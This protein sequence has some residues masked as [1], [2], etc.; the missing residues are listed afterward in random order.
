MVDLGSLGPLDPQP[1]WVSQMEFPGVGGG[2]CSSPGGWGEG[3]GSNNSRSL[4]SV[5]PGCFISPNI[6]SA[7]L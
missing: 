7:R 3:G 5:S 2:H 6:S 1:W 4:T